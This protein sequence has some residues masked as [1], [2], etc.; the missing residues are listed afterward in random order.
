MSKIQSELIDLFAEWIYDDNVNKDNKRNIRDKMNRIYQEKDLLQFRD[1][2]QG[3]KFLEGICN[4]FNEIKEYQTQIFQV[5]KINKQL[6]KDSDMCK[7]HYEKTL[8]QSILIDELKDKIKSI[9]NDKI[10]D[11]NNH[12]YCVHLLN[13]MND[14]ENEKNK[15]LMEKNNSIR[16]MEEM[17]EEHTKK[18]MEYAEY[19]TDET[20]RWEGRIDKLKN[21]IRKDVEKEFKQLSNHNEKE[22]T[23][24]L[25]EQIKRLQKKN[26]NL[27]KMNNKL[28]MKCAE[29]SSDSDAEDSDSD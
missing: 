12:P 8:E 14:L 15:A 27:K 20:A 6:K 13:K 1:Q 29:L 16:K 3:T 19:I 7:I 24:S 25:K 5:K 17:K 18:T 21:K 28:M 9:Q 23:K 22:L 2:T 10:T 26:L 4:L 11:F